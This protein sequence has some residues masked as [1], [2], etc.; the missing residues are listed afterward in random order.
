[1]TSLENKRCF[2]QELCIPTTQL[3]N[4]LLNTQSSMLKQRKRKSV[5]NFICST[6]PTFSI[7][8]TNWAFELPARS[9]SGPPTIHCALTIWI[10]W[11]NPYKKFNSTL[12]V[13][14]MTGYDSLSIFWV[15][16][17]YVK[18]FRYHNHNK[19]LLDET[20]SNI[21]FVLPGRVRLGKAKLSL[22]S[23]DPAK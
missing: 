17:S 19:H 1:M 12:N 22:T 8:Q 16:I 5:W 14:V 11:I 10:S 13:P 23:L 4:L 18:Q 7:S 20:E 2:P 21:R 15:G 9:S 3:I 6:V